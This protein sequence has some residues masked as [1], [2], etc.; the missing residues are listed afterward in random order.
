MGLLERANPSGLYL[1]GLAVPV[2]WS[3]VLLSLVW[4]GLL[5]AHPLSYGT[6]SIT[7]SHGEFQ[8]ELELD[9]PPQ[10][11]QA[12]GGTNA[13]AQA[14]RKREL[15]Q[16]LERGI[17]LQFD[18][19]KT[20]THAEVLGLGTGPDAVDTARIRGKVPHQPKELVLHVAYEVGELGVDLSGALLD[21][22]LRGYVGK[23]TSSAPIFLGITDKPQPW[24]RPWTK[25]GSGTRPSYRNADG[26]GATAG[27]TSAG[28]ASTASAEDGGARKR[29][30]MVFSFGQYLKLGFRHIVPHGADHVLFVIGLLL[31]HSLLA[32]RFRWLKQ[33]GLQLSLFTLS[34]SVTLALG[35]LGVVSVN[36]KLIEP[37]IALSIVYVGLEPLLAKGWSSKGEATEQQER[38]KLWRR[39]S[40]VLV[41]G[42]LHGLGFAS[43]LSVQ[44]LQEGALVTSLLAF[45][46]GVEAGQLF[47]AALVAAL[48][49]P[50]R[51]RGFYAR[52][53]LTPACA[54]IG[55][56]GA[57][58][59]I[60]RI[61]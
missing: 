38:V 9:S 31:T 56:V 44:G 51:M 25:P 18:G 52:F 5:C 1:R 29:R 59:F 10:Y 46:L 24:P 57:V 14:E 27:D 22:R 11:T 49:F 17:V 21:G 35:A 16:L 45:N 47:V 34:H 53:V 32:G 19:V 3:V 30:G 33:L 40:V 50:V 23:G 37:L 7:L 13:S 26:G 48:I 2:L 6:A 58:W 60:Q 28:G 20:Q 43:A 4:P 42:L 61:T 41:F 36:A 39:S 54:L 8:G 55:L 12:A 15:K